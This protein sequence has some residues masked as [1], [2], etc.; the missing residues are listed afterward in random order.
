MLYERCRCDCS[1]HCVDVNIQLYFFYGEC[2][3]D[4]LQMK[5]SE[6]GLPFN[7]R[8][9]HKNFASN[10]IK[11]FLLQMWGARENSSSSDL[12]FC[13]ISGYR[14][15]LYNSIQTTKWIKKVW[16]HIDII[17]TDFKNYLI[18]KLARKCALEPSLKIPPHLRH[19]I[20]LPCE[21]RTVRSHVNGRSCAHALKRTWP[22][23]C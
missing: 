17:L 15:I 9:N 2:N 8:R 20:T 5:C 6:R 14:I 16:Y 21:I 10:S 11:Y 1:G 23:W 4:Y 22:C 13:V 7:D 12:Y 3:I 18:G 19:V